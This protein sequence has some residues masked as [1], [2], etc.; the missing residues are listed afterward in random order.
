MPGVENKSFA[1][2][3]ETRTPSKTRVDVVRVGGTEPAAGQYA[4]V[5]MPYARFGLIAERPSPQGTVLVVLIG[6]DPLDWGGDEPG[7]SDPSEA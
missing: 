5:P 6:D 2:P 7:P 1:K 4:A 3:D